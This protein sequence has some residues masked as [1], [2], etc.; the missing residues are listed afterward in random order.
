MITENLDI[1]FSDFGKT[2]TMG[3]VSGLGI[4]DEPDQ[5][6]GGGLAISTDYSLLTK[7]SL[8]GNAGYGD[9][10]SVDGVA[11]SVREVRK[12]DDGSLCRMILTKV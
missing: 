10:I 11:Y 12:V 2:V 6:I 8:F 3:A 4:L 7:T 9:S 5:I 1:F